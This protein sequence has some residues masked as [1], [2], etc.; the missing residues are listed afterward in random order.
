MTRDRVVTTPLAKLD[1]CRVFHGI[2]CR[3][4]CGAG[5]RTC[6]RCNGRRYRYELRSPNSTAAVYR[7]CSLCQGKGIVADEQPT[8]LPPLGSR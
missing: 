8:E 3:F 7:E 2:D 4:G 5:P 1:D 6:P